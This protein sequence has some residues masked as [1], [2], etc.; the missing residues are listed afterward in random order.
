[1][2][3]QSRISSMWVEY[4]YENPA[5]LEEEREA[6]LVTMQKRYED[7][8]AKKQMP[9]PPIRPIDL[10]AEQKRAPVNKVDCIYNSS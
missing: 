7:Y 10:F 8:Q 3:V 5:K 4:L 1:M 6:H 2:T 9:E